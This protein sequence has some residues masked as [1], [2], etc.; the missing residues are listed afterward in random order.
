MMV[1][2]ITL[3]GRLS[4]EFPANYLEWAIKAADSFISRN[5]DFRITYEKDRD[6]QKWHYE[7]G[8]MAN[9]LYQLYLQTGDQKYY[10]FIVNN[11]DQFV[12]DEGNIRSYK[13]KSYKLDDIGPGLTLLRLYQET[14]N[15]KYK[16]AADQLRQQL[17]K[18]PRTSDG[19]FWHKQIYPYQMWLDGLYMAA[20]FYTEYAL[21]FNQPEDLDDVLKQFRLIQKHNYDAGTGLY[22]H[23]WDEKKVQIWANPETGLSPNYWGRSL[24]WYEMALVDVLELLPKGHPGRAELGHQL[25]ELSIVLLKYRDSQTKVWY[26]VLDQGDRAGN[27]LEASASIMSVYAFAKGTNLGF[28]DSDFYQQAKQSFNGVLREFVKINDDGLLDIQHVC[29]VAGL[30]GKT[31]R[32]G[33]FEY[34]ISEP[35]RTNDYKAVGPFILAAVELEKGCQQPSE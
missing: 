2:M 20:P 3:L 13:Q 18:Q 4:A 10:D 19:G 26:Q 27:Y 22:Y 5:P 34:Y 15:P 31:N 11:I 17:E 24:G 25:Q 7:Q 9:A 32:D 1:L 8:L 16:K 35:Q 30:G 14:E 6:R 23:G 33:S 12:D 29:S 21:M 28:L